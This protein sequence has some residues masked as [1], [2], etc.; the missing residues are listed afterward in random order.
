MGTG[1]PQPVHG[2]QFLRAVGDDCP[3]KI[4]FL[5]VDHSTTCPYRSNKEIKKD[6]GQKPRCASPLPGPSRWRRGCGCSSSRVAVA[7]CALRRRRGLLLEQ[8]HQ[9]GP[10]GHSWVQPPEQREVIAAEAPRQSD[11]FLS[12]GGL[13]AVPCTTRLAMPPSPL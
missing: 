2:N 7:P 9:S 5:G 12:S 3:L 8:L 1:D 6:K 13:V 10:Q 11:P 4:P